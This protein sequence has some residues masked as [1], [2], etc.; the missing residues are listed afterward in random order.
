MKPSIMGII[1]LD[2]GDGM[3]PLEYENLPEEV[4]TALT[5][6]KTIKV[7]MDSG[8]GDHVISPEDVAGFQIRPSAASIAGRGLIAANGG[9]IMNKGEVPVKLV[10]E[11]TGSKIDTTFQVVDVSRPLFSMS[12][13]CDQ[14]NEVHVTAKEAVVTRNGKVVA[15]FQREGGLYVAELSMTPSSNDPAVK[16]AAGFGR[17]GAH[18]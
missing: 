13:I 5:E 9:R 6:R 12:K 7:A 4:L 14:G 17:Q 18:A 1:D 11:P 10:E 2:I 3:Y 16:P 15:R 8:A